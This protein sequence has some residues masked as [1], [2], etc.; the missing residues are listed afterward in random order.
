AN[1]PK[2]TPRFHTRTRLKNGS[3]SITPRSWRRKISRIQILL[4]WSAIRISPARIRPRVR[5]LSFDGIQALSVVPFMF[6][7]AP[8]L[9]TNGSFLKPVRP[10]EPE[11]LTNGL[12]GLTPRPPPR[13]RSG[14]RVRDY[15]VDPPPAEPA[16]S[17]RIY[18][19][20]PAR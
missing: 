17:A 11:G 6:R 19:P 5:S 2:L 18:R 8:R 7:G 14:R 16:S 12:S 3:T 1:R 20:R 15:P 10:E 9:S 4:S 13:R